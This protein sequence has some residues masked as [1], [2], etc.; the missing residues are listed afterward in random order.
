MRHR[1]G[2]RKLGRTSSHR[3]ALLRHLVTSLFASEHGRIRTTLPKAKEARKVAERLITCAKRDDLHS[4]RLVLRT[5]ADKAVV[6]KLFAEVAPSFA[7]RPGGYTRVL[8]LGPRRGDNAEM[9]LLELV[10]DAS[11]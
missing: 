1:H 9:A 5:V 11:E 6:H 3:K 10:K 8:K 4:R 2:Y 7:T